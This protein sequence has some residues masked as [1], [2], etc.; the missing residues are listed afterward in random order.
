MGILHQVFCLEH[1]EHGQRSCT[2]QMVAAK[3]GTKLSIDGLELWC[4]QYGSHR[5]TVGD[6]LGHGDDVG[7]DAQPLVSEELTASTIA[8]LDL[9]ADQDC[10]VLLTGSSQSLG[11][12]WGREFDA[13]HTLDAL[14]DHSTHITL[15][16]FSLPG[17]QVVHRQIGHVTVVIDG[18][19][20]FRIVRHLHS[21]RGSSVESLL[22]R[23]HTGA[24]IGERGE[25]QGIL[26]GLGTA[27]DQKQLVV[28]VA[29]DLT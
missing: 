13:A 17:G 3:G 29:A 6:A 24:S 26:V 18:C 8:A 1:V 7:T 4:D 20:D 9:V 12:L 27:V 5:E 19:D 22:T 21:Q 25:F 16:Q 2:C 14:Q 23:E 28:V 15:C 10:A 11:E